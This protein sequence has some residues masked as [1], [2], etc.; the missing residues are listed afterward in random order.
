M[1]LYDEILNSLFNDTK[2]FNHSYF[3]YKMNKNQIK[4]ITF[5]FDEIPFK[6]NV[7]SQ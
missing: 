6:G 1:F 5:S 3:A 2:S 4:K 7:Y